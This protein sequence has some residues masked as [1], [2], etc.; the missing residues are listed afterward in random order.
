MMTAA[1]PLRSVRSEAVWKALLACL[2]VAWILAVAMAGVSALNAHPDEAAHIAAGQYYETHW[3]PPEA[4][5]AALLPS[6]STYG[7]TYLSSVDATYF[8][9]GKLARLVSAIVP[10]ERL[11][12]RAF[13]LLLLLILVFLYA[14]RRDPYSPLVLLLVTP[15]VWYVFSYFN[16]DALPLA[17]GLLLADAV[18]GA[19]ARVA[20]ALSGAWRASSL[21]PLAGC[22]VAIGLLVLTKSNYL[23]VLAFLGF[24]AFW[25]AFGLAAA[26]IGVACVGPYLA[27]LR[28]FGSV[29]E[30]VAWTSLAIGGIAVS[31]AAATRM[32]RSHATRTVVGRGALVL[33]AA[34]AVAVPPLAYDRFANGETSDKAAAMSAIAEQHAAPEYRPSSAASDASF[35]GL[36]LREKG[37]TLP[38]LL[39]APWEWPAKSW[40]SFTGTYG[41]MTIRG[42][43]AYYIVMFALYVALLAGTAR[44]V[45]Q[46]GEPGAWQLL[47]ASALFSAGI[48][49]L[50]LYHSWINDFQAQGRY[51]FPILVLFAIP[52]TKA[53]RLFRT[54]A[55]PALLGAAFVLSAAS[56]VFVA[57]R[58]IAKF[59]G[60]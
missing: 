6:L 25:T 10:D 31:A 56:F 43:T 35:F 3:L 7:Y 11:R 38:A 49:S 29:P 28:G 58:R 30:S 2:C 32:W 20:L 22:G 16:N 53:S 33:L 37:V 36:R 42:P 4:T 54:R 57:L 17:L 12:F 13:N 41:Y 34:L 60:P 1:D 27:H 8:F 51:L 50:S 55:V 46:R 40:K 5:E 48:V 59:Y 24:V 26:T 47:A 45:L 52:F 44:V 39:I 19:R 15:Q 21:L 18:F 23:P 14:A 9:A